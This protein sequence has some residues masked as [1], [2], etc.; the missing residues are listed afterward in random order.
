LRNSSGI[1][2]AAIITNPT[3]A[4]AQ[5][6]PGCAAGSTTVSG[7]CALCP[8]GTFESGGRC[9]NC[10]AG[11]YNDRDGQ[12]ECTSCPAQ[13]PNSPSEAYIVDQCSAGTDS[14]KIKVPLIIGMLL[15]V[16][17]YFTY[18]SSS[19]SSSLSSLLWCEPRSETR[20]SQQETSVRERRSTTVRR[21]QGW[22]QPRVG[23][24]LRRITGITQ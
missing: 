1:W 8:A 13:L 17:V 3:L 9:N 23:V 20:D 16:S 7:G 19:S 2:T 24:H 5:Q 21:E 4:G 6:L 15:L 10:T 11:K 18:L 14:K 12:T 22:N